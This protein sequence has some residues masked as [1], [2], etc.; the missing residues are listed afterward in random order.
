M[1]H[2]TFLFYPGLALSKGIQVNKCL[3]NPG[4]FVITLAKGYHAGFNMGFNCAEAVNFATKSWINLG[5]KAKS[6]DCQSGSVKVDMKYFMRNLTKN[7]KLENKDKQESDGKNKKSSGNKK[8]LFIDK[9]SKSKHKLQLLDIHE[10]SNP[11]DNL[12]L[13]RKRRLK[14]HSKNKEKKITSKKKKN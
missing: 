4:E 8:K 14:E 5:A 1:R 2:K 9:K 3:Q 11:N 6:C 13:K 7:K 12:F 10:P